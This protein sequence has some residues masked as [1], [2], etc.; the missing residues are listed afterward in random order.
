MRICIIGKFPPIEGGVST[1]TYWTAHALAAQGHEVHVVTNAKEVRAPFRMHMRGEDWARCEGA[2]SGGSVS[3][4]WTDPVDRSQFHIPMASAFVSKL[5]GVAARVHAERPFDV[6]L[7]YYIE[8]YG[9]AAHL[10]AQMTGAPHV[11]RMAGSDAGRLWKHAQLELLYSHVLRSAGA[12]IATGAVA[13]R[14]IAHGVGRERIGFD[15]GFALP[16]DVFTPFGPALDLA[17]LRQ[18]VERE[19]EFKKLLWGN[20]VPD[21][22]YFGCYGKLGSSKGSFALLS[23]MRELKRQGIQVGL[24]AMA[25]G[26][27][28]I[29][30][31]F[32]AEVQEL[33]LCD[34]VLQIPFLPNWRVPEFLRGCLAV[35]CLEQNFPIFFHAPIMPREVLLCGACLVGSTEIIRKLPGYARLPDRYGCAAIPDVEDVDA[36][37]WRLAAI[38]RDPQ[39]LTSVRARGCAFARSL[40]Q[41]LGF[42]QLLE[43]VLLAA[44]AREPLAGATEEPP[45]EDRF[46]LTR[47]AKR[48]IGGNAA[49]PGKSPSIAGVEQPVDLAVAR[50]VLCALEGA[51][52]NGEAGLHSLALAVRVENEI[53]VAEDEQEDTGVDNDPLFRLRASRW[54]LSD[55]DL[56]E[57]VPVRAPRLRIL[58]F[59]YD[60]SDFLGVTTIE[61]LPTR[62]ASRASYIAAFARSVNRTRDPLLVDGVTARILSLCDGTRT[63]SQLVRELDPEGDNATI[64]TYLKWIERLF[65]HD[66]VWLSHSHPVGKDKKRGAR[67]SST[68]R[69]GF[70]SPILGRDGAE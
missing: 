52:E 1:R 43:R 11:A 63:A 23:A 27:S 59:G 26:G 65:L 61:Q 42:P 10:A 49:D 58:E 28:G 31:R 20:L 2:Y 3:V 16:E 68:E 41:D 46:P 35:C 30:Q 62:P 9:V 5:A 4:H 53:A 8:P 38:V 70:L 15:G 69:P 22:P 36:L 13:E 48:M 25:H 33:S 56:A 17:S 64:D 67:N 29:D 6:I 39:P 19:P 21:L 47:L 7:S 66:L 40:Q 50:A 54:A 60:V 57:S 55:I 51:V 24:V 12:V 34:R 32:R 37:A 45:R 14:A 44:T 18:E